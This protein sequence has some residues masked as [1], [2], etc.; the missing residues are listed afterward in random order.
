MTL[1]VR[2]P[3][4]KFLFKQVPAPDRASLS[5]RVYANQNNQGPI[6]VNAELYRYITTAGHEG[7]EHLF[8]NGLRVR[9]FPNKV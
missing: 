1:S 2:Y 7:T 8:S 9:C 5:Q 3:G 4:V 6:A